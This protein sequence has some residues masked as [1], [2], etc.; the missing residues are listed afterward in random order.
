LDQG[1][2][3]AQAFLK[4]V[5]FTQIPEILNKQLNSDH[6]SK[7]QEIVQ[8]FSRTAPTYKVIKTE[9]PDH[10]KVFWVTVVIDGVDKEVGT[11]QSKQEAEQSAAALTL[12][13]MGKL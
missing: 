9:G 6:K 3:A 5:L 7:L 4:S 11:G 10:A 2:P 12:E 13:K 1:I 8:T